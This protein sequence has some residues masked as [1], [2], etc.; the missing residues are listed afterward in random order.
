MKICNLFFQKSS[1]CRRRDAACF[2]IWTRVASLLDGLDWWENHDISIKIQG[3]NQI[4]YWDIYIFISTIFGDKAYALEDKAR[5]KIVQS[6]LSGPHVFTKTK[7][8]REFI[9]ENK[10]IRKRKKTRSRPRKRFFIFSWS[11][12]C[13]FLFFFLIALLVES[14]FSFTNFHLCMHYLLFWGGNF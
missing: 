2:W 12:A 9:K 11:T 7:L 5:F 4:Y 1:K 14:V 13:F 6:R 8:R 3:D 10:K